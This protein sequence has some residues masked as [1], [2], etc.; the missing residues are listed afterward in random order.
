MAIVEDVQ[1]RLDSYKTDKQRA[2]RLKEIRRIFQERGGAAPLEF[3]IEAAALMMRLRTH[4]A[5]SAKQISDEMY[6]AAAT[7][8]LHTHVTV[9]GERHRIPPDAF[10]SPH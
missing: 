7:G 10:R 4:Q 6:T 8:E 9:D 2:R 5:I 3:A 1:T